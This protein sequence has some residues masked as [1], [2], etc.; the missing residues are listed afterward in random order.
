MKLYR[1][2]LTEPGRESPYRNRS[3]EENLMLFR[4]MKN[5]EFPDGHCVLRA[6]IDMSSGNINMRDPTLYRIKRASHPITGNQWCIYP[7]YDFAHAISDAVEEIT[8]SLCTLEFKDH[9]PL[10]DWTIENLIPSGFLTENTTKLGWRPSQYEFS[11]LNMQYTVLSKRKLIQLVTEKHVS[12]WDD[13]RMPTVCGLRRR[14]YPSE[15]IKLFCDR[16]LSYF[17]H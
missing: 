14:G 13:P 2:T 3:I 8:H 16:L 12:G 15:A 4:A 9:R 17:S 6:K 1:G 10:Y 5:G 7:M 11:R